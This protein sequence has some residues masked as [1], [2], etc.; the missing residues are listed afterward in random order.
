MMVRAS[1]TLKRRSQIR[2]Q[3]GDV[4]RQDVGQELA[5][6]VE[7]R[8]PFLD[9]G[10][11]ARE[12]VIEE[13]HSAASRAT[14]VPVMPMAMPMSAARKRRRVVD[15]IAGDGH[16]RAVALQ[17]LHDAE[18]LIGGDAGEQHIRRVEREPICASDI[19]RTRSPVM[20]AD[21]RR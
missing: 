14:S 5:D 7:D 4:R 17:R 16:D 10:D 15:A 18:L 2:D 21:R 20:T 13:H 9:R 3:F 1:G 6:V 11:D 8:P 12:V 19:R